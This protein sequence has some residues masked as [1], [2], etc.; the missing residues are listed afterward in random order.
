[1][2]KIH[3][4][5]NGFW[6]F[7]A[8]FVTT[9]KGRTQ[10]FHSLGADKAKAQFLANAIEMFWQSEMATDIN[11]EKV[12]SPDRLA[13]AISFGKRMGAPAPTTSRGIAA[14]TRPVPVFKPEVF[15]PEPVKTGEKTLHEAF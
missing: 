6:R 15:T 2:A 4:R 5:S 14:P 7:S 9:N 10:K 11:G 12:W 8:G 3:Q 1:M 13:E